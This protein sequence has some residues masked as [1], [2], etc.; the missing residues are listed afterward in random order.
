M[1]D[2]QWLE[3]LEQKFRGSTEDINHILE[4]SHWL[5]DKLLDI[6]S[7]CDEDLPV[8]TF[9][10]IIHMLSVLIGT[11]LDENGMPPNDQEIKEQCDD[12]QDIIFMLSKVVRDQNAQEDVAN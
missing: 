12:F 7:R 9:L 3:E 4:G 8:D 1:F 10:V 5:I 11:R 2:K 6:T